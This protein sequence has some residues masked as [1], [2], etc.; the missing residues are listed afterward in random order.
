MLAL[1]HYGSVE[2]YDITVCMT[3]YMTLNRY[4]Y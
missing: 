2:E 1:E 3:L 4:V